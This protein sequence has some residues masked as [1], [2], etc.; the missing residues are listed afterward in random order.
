MSIKSD[1]TKKV[2]DLIKQMTLDEKIAQLGSYWIYEL[3]TD[4]QLDQKKIEQKLGQGIG[5]ITRLAGASTFDPVNAAKAGN[6]IQRFLVERTRLGIPAILHEECCCGLISLGGS[7]FPQMI[8]LASTFEPPLAEAMTAAIRKQMLAIGARQGLS[9]VLDIGC[10]PRWGRI[11]ETFGEDPTL[12]SHFGVSYIKGLQGEDISQGVVAT[13][14]HFFGHSFSLGGLNCAPV[15]IGMNEMYQTILAPFQAAIREG[16]VAS[17]MNA[18]PELDGEVVAASSR[19]M[20]GILRNELG[21]KGPVVSDYEAISMLHTFHYRAQDLRSAACLALQ[22]GIDVEAPSVICYGNPLKDA[23]ERGDVSLELLDRSLERHLKMKVELGLFDNPYVDDGRVLEVYE[24]PDNRA[25]ARTIAQKSIVL[26]ENKGVLPLRKDIKKLAVIGPNADNERSHFGDYSYP[27]MMSLM[28]AIKPEGSSFIDLDPASLAQHSV[29]VI[30]I[31]DGIKAAVSKETQVLVAQGCELNSS[32]TSGFGQA[33]K[34]AEQADAVVMVLGDRSGLSFEC[35]T[36]EFRDCSTLRLPG[37]QEELAQVV[38]AAGKPVVAVL[39]NGRPYAIPWLSENAAAILEAWLPGEEGGNAVAD[40]LFGDVNPGAKLPL[41]FPRSVG[42]LPVYYNHKPTGRHSHVYGDYVSES[43]APLYPFGHG[44][45]Y[46]EFKYED[47]L[48][49]PGKA[50]SGEQVDISL[51]VTNSGKTAG[52]E[53]VQLYV[54]DEYASVPRPVKELKG[55]MRLALQTG[56]SKRLTFQLP[57]DML[58]FYNL[59]LELILEPGRVLLMVGSSSEDIRLQGEFE[60]T[61]AEYMTVAE[62]VFFCPVII[63]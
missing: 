1:I 6:Q 39:V 36:G 38:I 45:S 4:G 12:V 5:Q 43:T 34:V 24:T 3:Q 48:I 2:Q 23:L 27:S 28:Q 58:A 30:T 49:K 52:E 10:D 37:V 17:I 53:V 63:G 7:S 32:D 35:T 11:E 15:S 44:L 40:I 20:T 41:S 13:A 51:T 18:Y 8:G 26:L 9:P 19:I 47:L 60:I 57:V 55:Y 31:L 56:E 54:R 62:R 21:F 16:K 50:T 29:R 46:T 33:V 14:K 59:D 42:Q 25:L 61:G 22:A